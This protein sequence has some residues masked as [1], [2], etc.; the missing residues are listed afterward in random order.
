VRILRWNGDV[1]PTKSPKLRA[2]A[3]VGAVGIP[4]LLL[5]G[6]A[7]AGE[8]RGKLVG[9]DGLRPAA[10][11]SA[12]GDRHAFTV[13]EFDPLVPQKFAEIGADPDK[14][15]TLAVYAA[16]DKSGFMPAFIVRL[17]GG[18]ATPATAVVPP[19]VPILFRN[20]DPFTHKLVGEG[21]TRELAPGATHQIEP[22]GKGPTAVTDALL[23]SVRAWIVVEDGVV[24]DR[25][26]NHDGSIK[27]D[28]PA[29]DVT[30]KA[31]FEGKEKAA[32]GLKVPA[33]GAYEIKDPL[34]VGPVPSATA[35]SPG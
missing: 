28:L 26:A 9:A 14:D 5:I 20:D 12:S 21:W 10:Y 8:V 2:L 27:I 33:S 24:A 32:A 3:V 19:G 7:V 34:V 30:I 23:P 35:K 18:R 13:R 25:F 22:K 6:G 15:V 17:A 31:F 11:A 16:G 29:G 4:S 1:R